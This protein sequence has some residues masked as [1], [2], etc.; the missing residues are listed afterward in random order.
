MVITAFTAEMGFAKK[1][2]PLEQTHAL[3][4]E[5]IHGAPDAIDLHLLEGE[6]ATKADCLRRN[7]A[8][9]CAFA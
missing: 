3:L 2:Y 6:H 4:I 1:A 8:A 7:A 5:D 9:V